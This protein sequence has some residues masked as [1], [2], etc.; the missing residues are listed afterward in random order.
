M[1][2]ARRQAHAARRALLSP[3]LRRQLRIFYLIAL[4]LL[5]ITL[6]R[7]VRGEVAAGPALFA[8]A[9]GVALG[10]VVS[11]VYRLGWD[12]ETRTIVGEIDI[13]GGVILTLY[14][15]F[16][17]TKGRLIGQWVVDA[18]EA[19]VLGLGLTG[20]VML[21][22]VIFTSGGIHALLLAA[23]PR[24]Q[25]P[26]HHR[27]V[28]GSM[29]D[30]PRPPTEQATT[31]APASTTAH[32][33]ATAG[34]PEGGGI[35]LERL[36]FF[37]DAVFAIAITLLVLDI[38]I[39]EIPDDR[40]AADLPGSVAAV[41]P[42]ILA[43]FISF[44]II[45]TFWVVHHSTF[46]Y[47]RRYDHRLLWLNLYLLLFVAFLPFPA[48]IL[49]RY[50]NTFFAFTFYALI[51]IIISTL[52][53]T[54]WVHAT[55][56]RKLVEATLDIDVIRHRFYQGLLPPLVFAISIGFATFKPTWA[57]FIWFLIA[58]GR[59]STMRFGDRFGTLRRNVDWLV[60]RI[61][62]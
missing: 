61:R 3:K 55:R 43:Y 31:A 58:V 35:G 17:L 18:H 53:T 47:I 9:L 13:V 45:S 42:N 51:Q 28:G 39:P 6:Y 21:G 56:G 26:P 25:V 52:L 40:V 10:A 19:S 62:E 5:A 8:L 59:R 15:V 2:D 48:G 54:I 36:I 20:G 14:L 1:A 46:A 32:T 27:S 37:S 44:M 7:V 50:G 29:T 38:K 41:G 12:E 24:T 49:A 34:Q 16:A 22:R 23:D 33:G 30:T 57:F 60:F 11:R 4:V